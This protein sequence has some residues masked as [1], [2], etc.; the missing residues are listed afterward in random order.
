LRL[1]QAPAPGQS[2]G[3]P[4]VDDLSRLA[5]VLT[6]ELTSQ[7]DNARRLL[8]AST[9]ELLL[10]ALA[11]TVAA[12]VGDGVLAVDLVGPGRS[13]LRPEVDL[14]RTIGSFATIYPIALPC[15]DT[16]GASSMQLLEEVTRTT[17]SVPHHGVGHGLLRYLHA[18]T[19]G[20]LAA[21]APPD[22]FVSYLGMIPEWQR[23]DAPVQFDSDTGVAVRDTPPGLGHAIELRVYRHGGV[24]HID[25]WYDSRRV[26]SHIAEDLAERFPNL[27]IG[28]IDD[29]VTG[30]GS[31]E[32]DD[33]DE[34]LALVD[35]SAAVFDDD[36]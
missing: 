26:G 33:E 5:T 8:Q 22:V 13:V 18:P 10:A 4:G 36:E 2:D 21:I 20:L 28:L 30:D 6:L 32:E 3:P 29:A 31:D 15:M 24:L 19:A 17:K 16:A 12:T 1:A 23:S 35:L 34:A 25:W 11:R 27:L 7:V 9:E 14:H